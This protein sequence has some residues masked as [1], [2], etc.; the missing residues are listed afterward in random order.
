MTLNMMNVV[1]TLT[2]EFL[3]ALVSTSTNYKQL[4]K[5][6][7]IIIVRTIEIHSYSN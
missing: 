7:C 4:T 6:T 2:R 5:L 3:E 1:K